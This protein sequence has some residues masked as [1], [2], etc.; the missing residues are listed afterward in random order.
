MSRARRRAAAVMAAVAAGVALAVVLLTGAA[1]GN[2]SGVTDIGGNTSA[3]LYAAGHR[4]LAPEFSGTTLTGSRLSVS[5]YRGKV[6]VLNFWGSWCAPCREEAPALAALA[7]TYRGA[8]VAFL[9][10]DVRDTDASAQAFA[11]DFGIT[12]PSV[13]DPASVVTMDFTTVVPIAGTPTTLV[14]DRTRHIAGA[15]FGAATYSELATILATVT[16]G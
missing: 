16:R 8:G 3:V 5:A 10:V 12:Y 15:V 6:V 13:A 1:N 4:P 11:R 2:S 14:I 9:G 7:R